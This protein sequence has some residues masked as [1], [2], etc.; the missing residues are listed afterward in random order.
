MNPADAPYPRCVLPECSGRCNPGYRIC[1]WC[2]WGLPKRLQREY[3]AAERNREA[4]HAAYLIRLRWYV[5]GWLPQSE[6]R[7]LETGGA[8]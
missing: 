6:L 5:R 2:F 1:G 4:D 8:Q 7:S 3:R